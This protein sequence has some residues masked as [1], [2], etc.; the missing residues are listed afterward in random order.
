MG[1]EASKVAYAGQ[2]SDGPGD[3]QRQAKEDDSTAEGA[4]QAA[5]NAAGSFAGEGV[6]GESAEARDLCEGVSDGPEEA[7]LGAAMGD[8]VEEKEQDEVVGVYSGGGRAWIA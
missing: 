1:A 3:R 8:L 2:A 4:K 7:E 6:A 5:R